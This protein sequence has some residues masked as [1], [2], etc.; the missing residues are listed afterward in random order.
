MSIKL[1]T[2]IHTR[3]ATEVIKR[4]EKQLLNECIRTIYNMI[5]MNP[6]K[7]VSYLHQLERVLDSEMLEDCKNFIHRVI[8]CR[9]NRVLERQKGKF[10][11]LVQQKTNGR[12]NEDAQ[13]IGI[14]A[15]TRKIKK[16]KK[17]K[18]G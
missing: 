2:N 9:H 17:G 12:S 3:K 1:K 6:D 5:E 7:R 13:K 4:A 10:E 16:R 14:Q 11:A 15:T 18:S 8:E